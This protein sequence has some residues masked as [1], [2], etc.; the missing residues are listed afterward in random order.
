MKKEKNIETFKH[1]TSVYDNATNTI[2]WIKC[3][4]KMRKWLGKL[5]KKTRKAR[6]LNDA[7]AL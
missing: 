2:E 6:K 4:K 5:W 3:R 1:V 7:N